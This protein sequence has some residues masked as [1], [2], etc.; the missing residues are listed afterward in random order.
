MVS[1]AAMFLLSLM[2]WRCHPWF[3]MTMSGCSKEKASQG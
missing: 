2:H 1:K 3:R